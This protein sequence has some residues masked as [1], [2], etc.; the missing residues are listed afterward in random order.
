MARAL[1]LTLILAFALPSAASAR[2]S[3]THGYRYDQLW[4]SVVRMVRVDYGFTV[5]D[6]DQ[7]IGYVLFD[8]IDGGRA[9]PASFELVRVR[10]NGRERVRVSVQV[11]SMPSYVERMLLDRLTRKLRDEYGQPVE[12]PTSREREAPPAD[13]AAD[14]DR[15]S[16]EGTSDEG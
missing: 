8:Y 7:D 4:G 13:D 11:P 3:D 6:R 5:R 2:R 1:L 14:E 10:E 9:H 16:E 12:M 15:D